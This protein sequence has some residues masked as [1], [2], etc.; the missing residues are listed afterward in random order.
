LFVLDQAGINAVNSSVF[1][2]P[3]SGN[4]RIGLET[5]M[6]ATHGGPDSFLAQGSPGSTIVTPQEVVPEPASMLL[7]GGGLIGLA[8]L[9]R[10]KTGRV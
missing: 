5:T 2:T 9:R 3:G 8:L 6:S 10:R 4:V 1:S 7:L